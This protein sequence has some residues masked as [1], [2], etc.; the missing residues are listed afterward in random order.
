M[1]T[2]PDMTRRAWLVCWVLLA[3]T[4]TACSDLFPTVDLSPSYQPPEYVV[5]AS[6]HGSSPFVEATP[7]DTE[8][9]PDWW[10]LYDDPALTTLIEQA[11]V[12]NPDLASHRRAVCPGPRHDDEGPFSVPSSAGPWIRRLG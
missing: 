8:L 6:W 11:M 1:H 12:A 7:S 5:P 2:R 10:Q 3:L 9:R 4:L